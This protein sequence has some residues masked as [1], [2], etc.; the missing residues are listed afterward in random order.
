MLRLRPNRPGM[1]VGSRGRFFAAGSRTN[2][3]VACVIADAVYCRIVVYDRGVVGIMDFRDI[4]V[5]H[6]AVVVK[7]VVVPAAA[8]IT[9]AKIAVAVI[10]AAVKTNPWA[11]ITLMENK[12]TSAPTP[13]V[14]RPEKTGIRSQHPGAGDLKIIS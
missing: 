1:P 2:A 4:D 5:V 6:R 7:A 9:A 12:D 11:P 14:W 8:F 10:Y 13:I 3:V